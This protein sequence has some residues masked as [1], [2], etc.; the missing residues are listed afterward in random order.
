MAFKIS[1]DATTWVTVADGSSSGASSEMESIAINVSARYIRYVG[2]GNSSND[3]NSVQEIKIFGTAEIVPYVYVPSGIT[4][5]KQSDGG[6]L[7]FGLFLMALG[8]AR[9][10]FK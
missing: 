1:D 4:V 9:R 10:I 3:W 6:S 5:K 8:L 2:F 7:G